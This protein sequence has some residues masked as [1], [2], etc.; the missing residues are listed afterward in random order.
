MVVDRPRLLP[1]AGRDHGDAGGRLRVDGQLLRRRPQPGGRRAEHLR[2]AGQRDGHGRPGQAGLQHDLSA[3]SPLVT[4]AS[5][6][7]STWT[8]GQRLLGRRHAATRRDHQPV[9]GDQRSAGLQ[10]GS[11]G[12]TLVA[13]TK[14]ASDGTYKSLRSST[15]GTHHVQESVPS[16]YVQTGGGPTGARET[17]TTRSRP[18]EATAIPATSSTT[19]SSPPASRPASPTR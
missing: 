19:T 9:P 1:D 5:A 18:P 4:S 12:D 10:T 8:Y 14:T 17:P 7:P 2:R 13:T 15:A 3:P 6:G 11:G 16:G